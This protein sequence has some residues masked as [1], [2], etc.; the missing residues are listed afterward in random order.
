VNGINIT[1]NPGDI[2]TPVLFSAANNI[3]TPANVT[4]FAFTNASVRS[5]ESLVSV[6]ITAT[7]G[8]LYSHYRLFGLQKTTGN[9]VINT[10]FIGDNSGVVFS[11]A[12]S[13]QVQYSSTNI[14]SFQS[15]IMAFE[16]RALPL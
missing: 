4:N 13:G 5:F 16:A 11:M 9:W 3:V 12:T 2:V 15:N 7:A 8:N 10:S 6:S 1:P 14:P